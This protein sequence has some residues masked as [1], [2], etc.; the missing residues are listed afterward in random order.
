MSSSANVYFDN[1][2]VKVDGPQALQEGTIQLILKI[3]ASRLQAVLLLASVSLLTAVHWG[4]LGGGGRRRRRR[5]VGCDKM[6]IH[7]CH[8]RRCETETVRR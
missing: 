4:V 7:A 3:F 1:T 5:S 8:R 6:H 2:D